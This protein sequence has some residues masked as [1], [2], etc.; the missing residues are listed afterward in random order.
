ME[1]FLAV[2]MVLGIFVVL[3]VI[4]ALVV[5]S[6]YRFRVPS[7][8]APRT[9]EVQ[10]AAKGFNPLGNRIVQLIILVLLCLYYPLIYY[11][12]ELID[13]FGWEALRWDFFYTVHDI[14]RVVFLVPILF[15][16][17]FFKIKGTVITTIFA[18][19]V[20][21]PRGLLLSPYPDPMSRMVV[22]I[23][24]ALG[25]GIFISMLVNKIERLQYQIDSRKS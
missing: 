4:I 12:G 21:L 8:R 18:L 25:F 11:F 24:F 5:I 3:P 1:T 20:F 22:F 14:H 7:V 16:A 2:L 17:Y 19:A 23:I 6:V 15:A 13:H 9:G 10:A